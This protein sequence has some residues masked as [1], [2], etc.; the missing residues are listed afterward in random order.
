MAKRLQK[1]LKEYGTSLDWVT[2]SLVDDSLY[3]WRVSFA[4]PAGSPYEKG[5]FTVEIDIPQEYPFK[6]PKF[7]FITKVYHPNVKSEDGSI[8]TDILGD[9]W[10]P[11][12]KIHEVLLTLKSLMAEPNP[13]NPL[14]PEIGNQFTSDRAAFDKT[15]KEWTKKHATK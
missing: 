9:G 12:L 2:A 1:E 3:K 15:A 10:S 11:Q 8:C 6:P 4:G 7:K 14:E 13:E 5:N